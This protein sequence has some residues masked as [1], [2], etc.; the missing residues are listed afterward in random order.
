MYFYSLNCWYYEGDTTFILTSDK[1]YTKEQFYDLVTDLMVSNY[2]EE[3]DDDCTDI[4]LSYAVRDLVKL[5]GFKHL[6]YETWFNVDWEY[7]PDTLKNFSDKQSSKF[8]KVFKEKLD[9]LNEKTGD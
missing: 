1:Q 9:K 8:I 3:E 6:R 7:I 5:Y 2:N 4:L